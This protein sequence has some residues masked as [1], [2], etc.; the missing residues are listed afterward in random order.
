METLESLLRERFTDPPPAGPTADVVLARIASTRRSQRAWSAAAAVVV[1]L[2]ASFG[3]GLGLN[4]GAA[5]PTT[6]ASAP[7][8]H[9]AQ[10]GRPIITDLGSAGENASGRL[11]A[12]LQTEGLDPAGGMMINS[13][14][15][16]TSLWASPESNTAGDQPDA[17]PEPYWAVTTDG[18]RHYR[19][20]AT[21]SGMG[22]T[23]LYM[24]D[25]NHLVLANITSVGPNIISTQR[26]YTSD[27]GRSWHVVSAAVTGSLTSIPSGTQLVTV[28][29]G[30]DGSSVG[31]L[32][33]D[34]TARR[35]T[36]VPS[37]SHVM[38]FSETAQTTL[39]YTSRALFYT[40]DRG[41]TWHPNVT[42]LSYLY[43][44]IDLGVF[45]GHHYIHVTA[46]D[47]APGNHYGL[48]DSTDGGAHWQPVAWPAD[49]AATPRNMS[50]SAEVV[51]ALGVCVSDGLEVWCGTDDHLERI[52]IINAPVEERGNLLFAAGGTV[53]HPKLY[54]SQDGV[55]WT[56]VS[57]SR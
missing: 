3:L 1:V 25:P 18:G 45:R 23:Q 40:T 13:T 11:N 20:L 34:G 57:M 4:G 48:F 17:R 30:S 53:E 26:A 37:G 51:P 56:D 46:G 50:I 14:D 15:G 29:V 27:G 22:Q 8:S 55:H 16:F 28:P 32:Y 21:P 54:S 39:L 12:N 41:R 49:T 9:G 2:A 47:P 35:L 10:G 6:S 44:I 36:T 7:M 43:S 5:H 31:V 52:P 24:F 38:E 33:P 42:S 19:A